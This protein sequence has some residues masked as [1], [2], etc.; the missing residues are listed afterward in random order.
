MGTDF[1]YQQAGFWYNNMDKL[2]KYNTV[3]IYLYI[4]RSL[5]FIHR[6]VN[7]RQVTNESKINVLYSTPSCYLKAVHNEGREWTVKEDDFFPYS[8]DDYSYWTGYYTSRP[9]LKYMERLGNNFLQVIYTFYAHTKSN[10]IISNKFHRFANS[11]AC[12][13]ISKKKDGR[14]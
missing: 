10:Y 12:W 2:I 13:Q 1:S 8:S 14:I 11:S 6:Y 4:C 3:F 7:E 9:T 5:I